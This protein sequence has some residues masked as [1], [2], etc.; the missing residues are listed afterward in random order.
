[1]KPHRPSLEREPYC[2]DRAFQ[3]ATTDIR[4]AAYESVDLHKNSWI[5]YNGR[6]EES[7]S[8]AQEEIERLPMPVSEPTADAYIRKTTMHYRMIINPDEEEKSQRRPCR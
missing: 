3:N 4:I 1:M 5:V 8:E 2:Y 6:D 7:S